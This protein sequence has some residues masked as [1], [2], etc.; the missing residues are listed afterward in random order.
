MTARESV[1]LVSDIV[2]DFFVKIVM[3]RTASFLTGYVPVIVRVE[4]LD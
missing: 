3:M 1:R 2:F 4:V